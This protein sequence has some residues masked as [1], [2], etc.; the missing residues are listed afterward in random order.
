MNTLIL[1]FTQCPKN[2]KN[3]DKR[4]CTNP[5]HSQNIHGDLESNLVFMRYV[6]RFLNL[7]FLYLMSN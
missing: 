5:G 3:G 1:H 2:G 4:D 7:F 6:I